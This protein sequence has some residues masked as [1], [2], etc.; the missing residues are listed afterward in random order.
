MP[1]TILL[2]T[3]PGIDD[4]VA[5][6]LALASPD[7][8]TL[9]AITVIA[10]NVGLERTVANAIGL[11]ALSGRPVPV[12]AGAAKALMAP[13]PTASHVHGED[14][15]IGLPLPAHE[16]RPEPTH[17]VDFLRARLR[18]AASRSVTLVFIGPLTNLALA[19]SIEPGIAAAVDELVIM[20]GAIGLGNITASAEFNIWA[21]PEAASIVFRAGIPITLVP[22][23]LTHQALATRLHAARL[24]AL[25]RPAADA[26]AYIFETSVSH[27]R[28]GNVGIPMHDVCAIAHLIEPGLMS[29]RHVHV[30]IDCTQGPTRGRTIVDWWERGGEAPNATVLDR[31]DPE[32]FFELLIERL[33]R[34]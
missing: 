15:L 13:M 8:I 30:E 7:A 28:F 24:R 5:I 12:Y 11:V 34:L 33:A 27:P 3:D 22:L 31:I 9:E 23:D 20:G 19:L 17:A 18:D 6:L 25:R 16:L 32:P 4:A 29:G 21:D 26:V 2:D 1:R 14:G 10:G